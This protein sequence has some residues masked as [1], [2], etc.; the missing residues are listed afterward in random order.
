MAPVVERPALP[1]QSSSW[2]HSSSGHSDSESVLNLNSLGPFRPRLQ[3]SGTVTGFSAARA[4]AEKSVADLNLLHALMPKM[5]GFLNKVYSSSFPCVL[6][7]DNTLL[8]DRIGG[9]KH[10]S[11]PERLAVRVALVRYGVSLHL[12]KEQDILD[13]LGQ[14]D[15]RKICMPN[16]PNMVHIINI[17]IGYIE[18]LH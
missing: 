4:D 10:D 2:P 8:V 13:L 14:R 11:E 6:E 5:H 3:R 16:S 17:L 9:G 1:E 12:V 18:L 7:V 15:L